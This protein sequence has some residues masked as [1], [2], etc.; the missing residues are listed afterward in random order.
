MLFQKFS[1]AIL[2]YREG[3]LERN[4]RLVENSS[5]QVL[6]WPVVTCACFTPLGSRV[7]DVDFFF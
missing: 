6:C 5:K 4:V 2:I 1:A 7:A 3:T